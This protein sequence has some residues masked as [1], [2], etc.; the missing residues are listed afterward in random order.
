MTSALL[1]L[2]N[3]AAN[4]RETRITS[5]HVAPSKFD[6]KF[7]YLVRY[8][9]LCQG[10]GR[11]P[12]LDGRDR[13]RGTCEHARTRRVSVHDPSPRR[14]QLPTVLPPSATL[15]APAHGHPSR[16][17]RRRTTGRAYM[18][19]LG[20]HS[21]FR[22]AFWRHSAPFS[23]RGETCDSSEDL[24]FSARKRAFVCI[25]ITRQFWCR[26]RPDPFSLRSRTELG[27]DDR[28]WLC[29]PDTSMRYDGGR[30]AR[31]PGRARSRK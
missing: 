3:S 12:R 24:N 25:T 17:R 22:R 6:H 16:F 11:P 31:A 29:R 21:R 19:P 23:P 9:C 5:R 7:H 28:L 14:R 27:G 18:P 30:R 20:A 2:G 26:S 13:G 15:S 10:G 8:D 4:R 1:R